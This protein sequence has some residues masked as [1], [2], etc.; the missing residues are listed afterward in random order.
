MKSKTS[1]FNT[2]I[3]KKNITH[4]WPL[5]AVYLCYLLAI[6]PLDIWISMSRFNYYT[7]S[8]TLEERGYRAMYE[9]LRTGLEPL[10]VFV[11][12]VIMA[13]AVFSYLYSPRNA[14]MIHS[15]PVTRLELYVTNCLSGLLFM[16][17]P[18]L[19]TFLVSVLVCIAN[20]I[21]C[22]Q[23]LFLWFLIIAGMTF[24]AYSMAVFIAM[25][26]GQIFAMPVYYFVANYLYV[27]CLYFICS[28]VSLVSYGVSDY[29]NPGAS[30]ILSPIYYLGNNLRVREVYK[31][32]SVMGINITG[33]RLV[34]IYA[35]VAVVLL[36]ATYQLYKRRQIET[37]GDLISIGIVKPIF[38]W[39]VALCGGVG[40]SLLV[41]GIFSDYHKAN[42]F[43]VIVVSMLVFGF[44]CF[45]AAEMMLQKSFRVFHRKAFLEWSGFAVAAVVFLSLFKID[46]FGIERRIPKLEEIQTAFI[47]MDY[48]LEVEEEELQTLLNIHQMAIDNKDFYLENEKNEIGYYYTTIRYYLKNGSKMERRYPVPIGEEYVDDRLSV[49]GKILTWER[50]PENMKRQILGKNYEKN[51]YYSG[52]VERYDEDGNRDDYVL[53]G[54]EMEELLAAI[55]EDIKEGNFD[56]YYLGA[57]SGEENDSYFNGI[58]LNYSSKGEVYDNWDYYERY[59]ELQQGID[60]YGGGE[61]SAS[62]YLTFGP[63]CTCTIQALEDLDIINDTWRLISY[64]EYESLWQ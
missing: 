62:N 16:L 19:I 48:P 2:T 10:P 51:K 43:A 27:G 30:C 4:Y 52:S 37:A 15:F 31:N 11:F 53:T 33:G 8:L 18:E 12:S 50:D 61:L 59:R 64:D 38:R 34:G 39:G 40:L 58:Y 56:R 49:S 9:V 1:C 35:V 36:I 6:L 28:L 45:F 41:A 44:L 5:W 26:A 57:L 22:I 29:W 13:L 3:F 24:F 14:N 60:L 54:E 7:S 20:Q 55:D 32:E 21:T 63:G 47:Y 25:F 17:V 23:Y 46:A 42:V